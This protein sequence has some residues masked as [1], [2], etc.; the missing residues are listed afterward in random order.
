MIGQGGFAP[1]TVVG[2][3]G[4]APAVTA[5]GSST[6]ALMLT[7][8]SVVQSHLP[9]LWIMVMLIVSSLLLRVSLPACWRGKPVAEASAPD[10]QVM[11]QIGQHLLRKAHDAVKKGHYQDAMR[12]KTHLQKYHQDLPWADIQVGP[13]WAHRTVEENNGSVR[14]QVIVD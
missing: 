9:P 5:L 7:S 13:P 12:Y 6:Y 4:F 3:G 11:A 8:V 1:A 2:H 14:V 10:N